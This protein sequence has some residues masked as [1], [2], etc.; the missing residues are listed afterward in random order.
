MR[1][2]ALVILTFLI[3]TSNAQEAEPYFNEFK[4]YHEANDVQ[5]ALVYAQRT[6]DKIKSE[7]DNNY[8]KESGY[9]IP[10]C[11]FYLEK[12]N[13]AKAITTCQ[14]FFNAQG[15][16][17]KPNDSTFFKLDKKQL[18]YHTLHIQALKAGET[19]KARKYLAKITDHR[20]RDLYG[21]RSIEY[22]IYLD[23]IEIADALLQRGTDVNEVAFGTSLLCTAAS[24]G[25]TDM[26]NFLLSQGANDLFFDT[27]G[28]TASEYAALNG[29]PDLAD[30]IDH[31]VAPQA[32]YEAYMKRVIKE[33]PQVSLNAFCFLTGDSL[34]A[35]IVAFKSVVLNDMAT[36]RES[37]GHGALINHFDF[38][39]QLLGTHAIYTNN[40]EALRILKGAGYNLFQRQANGK[41]LLH[42]AAEE[43]NANMV[44]YLL[45]EGL[46]PDVIDNT[47]KLP[48]ELIPANGSKLVISLLQ[49]GKEKKEDILSF[50]IE[51]KEHITRVAISP[52]N[53]TMVTSEHGS[54]S[55][56]LWDL[57]TKMEI[58]EIALANEPSEIEFL[59]DG[60]NLLIGTQI[61]SVLKYDLSTRT[62]NTLLQPEPIQQDWYLQYKHFPLAIH[63]NLIATIQSHKSNSAEIIL[64]DSTGRII[65]RK[66]TKEK[67]FLVLTF[68]DNGK[69]LSGVSYAGNLYIWNL[70]P[71]MERVVKLSGE[72]GMGHVDMCFYEDDKKVLVT[73]ISNSIQGFKTLNGEKAL[74]I[75]NA[76]VAKVGGFFPE[77][78]S[79]KGAGKFHIQELL[80]VERIDQQT[81]A[82]GGA[83]AII[84]IW[85]LKKGVKVK[86]IKT[87]GE[88]PVYNVKLLKSKDL[89]FT[90]ERFILSVNPENEAMELFSKSILLSPH[91][92]LFAGQYIYY[93][94]R[95]HIYQ[96]DQATLQSRVISTTKDSA[97][98]SGFVPT[99]DGELYI[100]E[101]SPCDTL[102]LFTT[103]FGPDKKHQKVKHTYQKDHADTTIVNGHE[104]ISGLLSLGNKYERMQ[105]TVF[106]DP[107]DT[108]LA[109]EGKLYVYDIKKQEKKF[110]TKVNGVG[111]L[112]NLRLSPKEGYLCFLQNESIVYL[113]NLKNKASMFAFYD[114]FRLNEVDFLEESPEL[115]MLEN[116][117]VTRFKFEKYEDAYDLYN[118]SDILFFLAFGN[119]FQGDMAKSQKGNFV[120][121]S[122]Y[123]LTTPSV[124]QVWNVRKKKEE[125]AYIDAANVLE[126][127][128]TDTVL[129]AGTPFGNVSLWDVKNGNGLCRLKVNQEIIKSIQFSENG[130]ILYV[131]T[132]SSIV[133]YDITS[134]ENPKLL[135]RYFFRG[136]DFM[137]WSASGY[138]FSTPGF[139]API[140]FRQKNRAFP[141]EQF[142]LQYN[143]PD[144][145]LKELGYASEGI[146]SLY[147]RAYK[148][149]LETLKVSEGNAANPL[150]VP[151]STITNFS[152]LPTVSSKEQIQL[153]L[154][155]NDSNYPIAGYNIWMNGVPV[156][157]HKGKNIADL[158]VKS[159][160]IAEKLD[161]QVGKNIIQVSCL[162][163]NLTESFK[164]T[165]EITHSPKNKR[166]PNL[167]LIGIG[168]S[169]YKRESG[170]PKLLNV[171]NDIRDFINLYKTQKSNT[172]DKITIDTIMNSEA[173]KEVLPEIKNKLKESKVD[174]VIIV[175]YS[176]HGD[177][178]KDNKEYYLF[179]HD[180]DPKYITDRSIPFTHLENLL[181]SIPARR[182]LLIVN[183]CR[184]G[185]F[186][187]DPKAFDMMSRL[188]SDLRIE[189]GTTVISSSSGIQD[190]FTGSKKYGPHSA[191]GSTLLNI[192][193]STNSLKVSELRNLLH[194][195]VAE[196]TRNEQKPTSRTVNLKMDFT[197]W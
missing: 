185:E 147:N 41:T 91:H 85:N 119:G 57:K 187:T 137:I 52:D 135:H 80:D 26:V 133:S 186:N 172:F 69:L 4:K 191:F 74:Y 116:E 40:I 97:F 82:T 71:W 15:K 89:I 194:D 29:Y 170:I 59:P 36:L 54:A 120:A 113:L 146:T 19:E 42:V 75:G 83:D 30:I 55:M 144:L 166:K 163:K 22:A 37:I 7:I 79:V 105:R 27:Q 175:F 152:S 24:F 148:K 176:G 63:N 94:D 171:D 111:T 56:K 102:Q 51:H 48:A 35:T 195:Q 84:N 154:Q 47:G 25:K 139:S 104:V 114:P 155:F 156:F 110:I 64:M 145:I 88:L 72:P 141:F 153:E 93:S 178:T 117:E 127:A 183:A 192:L 98:V 3:Y 5:K 129:A 168:V 128:P 197:I 76:D 96:L 81:I 18:L 45:K 58:R 49:S 125:Y 122:R 70:N 162:N 159:F 107:T 100:T 161:L 121:F 184:S 124:V 134:L 190:S 167:F 21:L 108:T 50:Q 182:K 118:K 131:T 158:N 67:E 177:L 61:G 126:F 44:Q 157:G 196:L 164:E 106:R 20:A 23:N 65:S 109:G 95:E 101:V 112:S 13:E 189:T 179:M 28:K 31:N 151:E 39:G 181:D 173:T 60:R 53:K 115:V 68:S 123:E 193:N 103:F 43:D 8:L 165:I 46:N 10:L 2:L 169:D 150:V 6:I 16:N 188:F 142:D 66:P 130:S 12:G 77:D 99:G 143:R 160:E 138:Y 87:V 62:Y 32:V 14:L 17:E 73:G 90:K 140:G 132:S 78:V 149:R 92:T 38:D 86:E 33:N 136:E 174:D 180:T 9:L 11:E 34:Y 1:F